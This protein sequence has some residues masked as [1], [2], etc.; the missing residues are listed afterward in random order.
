M[1][2]SFSIQLNKVCTCQP[3]W[4]QNEAT[5]GSGLAATYQQRPYGVKNFITFTAVLFPSLLEIKDP[6]KD[7]FSMFK[8]GSVYVSRLVFNPIWR[9]RE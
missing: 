6:V 3:Y 9:I 7:N 8:F 5:T 4:I 2:A 1:V